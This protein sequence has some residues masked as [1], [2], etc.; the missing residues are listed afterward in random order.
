MADSFVK[1]PSD[2][3]L[4]GK[5]IR[6]QTVDLGDGDVH[7][8]YFILQGENNTVVDIVTGS[9]PIWTSAKKIPVA[10]YARGVT[11]W[12][13]G[14]YIVS[15]TATQLRFSDASTV[16]MYIQNN[17]TSN[18]YIG[19]TSSVLT[20]GVNMGVKIF[21]GGDWSIEPGPCGF[22]GNVWAIGDAVA[23]AENVVVVS[24]NMT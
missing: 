22:G 14:G 5:Q 2:T 23:V 7:T 16:A 13:G 10:T 15:N 11:S 12:S 8:H 20:S 24:F 18:V 6:T 4:T 19:N 21:P 9:V 3:T 17:G 1:L